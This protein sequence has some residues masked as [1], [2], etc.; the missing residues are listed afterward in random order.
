MLPQN[1]KKP[2]GQTVV[3]FASRDADE[4]PSRLTPF[5]SGGRM[6]D[7]PIELRYK[8]TPLVA[9]SGASPEFVQSVERATSAVLVEA[10]RNTPIFRYISV[11]PKELVIPPRNEKERT[12]DY[13]PEGILP[14]GWFT[15]LCYKIPC[16]VVHIV[17]WDASDFKS[18]EYEHFSSIDTLRYVAT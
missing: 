10:K 5:T 14:T 8:P 12:A 7:F 3:L 13:A 4:N 18:R 6:N 15:A 16:A 17:E 9:I 11:F 2:Y 1:A